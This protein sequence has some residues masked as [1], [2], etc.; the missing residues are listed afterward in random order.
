MMRYKCTL[1][2]G[3][4]TKVPVTS[5][6]DCI[7]IA[8]MHLAGF[9]CTWYHDKAWI[10]TVSRTRTSTIVM[11]LLAQ[12]A[13][14]TTRLARLDCKSHQMSGSLGV[15]MYKVHI[16]EVITMFLRRRSMDIWCILGMHAMMHNGIIFANT[17][18]IMLV[19][20]PNTKRAW[21]IRSCMSS[22]QI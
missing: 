10:L 4:C 14:T 8:R 12:S 7:S 16:Y 3:Y 5:G 9:I 17:T 13:A 21:T 20:G 6:T 19:H 2:D 18:K 11:H 22:I 1:L 15:S